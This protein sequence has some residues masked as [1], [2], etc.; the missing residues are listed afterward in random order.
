MGLY[1]HGTTYI[2]D[3]IQDNIRMRLQ[4]DRINTRM[5]HTLGGLAQKVD[6]LIEGPTHTEV[7]SP[8]SRQTRAQPR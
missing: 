4:T 2:Q 3:S 6:I 8:Q 5:E 1:T 7:T